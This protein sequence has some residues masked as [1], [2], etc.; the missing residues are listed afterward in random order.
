ME[1]LPNGQILNMPIIP[2]WNFEQTL[3]LLHAE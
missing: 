2:E 1:V 3:D